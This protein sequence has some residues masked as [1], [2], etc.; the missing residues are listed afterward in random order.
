MN[1]IVLVSDPTTEFPKN[2]TS[3]F[4]VR[5]PVPLELKGEGWKVGLAAISTPDAG[6][7]LSRLA[8]GLKNY[9]IMQYDNLIAG[10]TDINS[11]YRHLS[12]VTVQDI[13]GDLSIVDGVSLMKALI[14]RIQK[15][16]FQQVQI[17]TCGK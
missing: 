16:V 4:K 2:S 6:L 12:P 15:Y 14:F 17:T 11:W 3:S 8:D 5:L 7:D 13:T 9:V 10:L 1:R